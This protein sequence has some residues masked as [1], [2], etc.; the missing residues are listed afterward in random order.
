MS[1]LVISLAASTAFAQYKLE[2]AAALPSGVPD[3]FAALLKKDGGHKILAADGKVLCEVWMRTTTPTGPAT[4]EQNVSLPT[5]PHGSFVG[6]IHFPN[7]WEDRRG[8]TIKP[9]VYTMRYSMF[10]T[11]GDHQGAAPQRDFFLLTPM[12]ND[13]DPAATPGFDAL[14]DMSRKASN[15]PHPAVFSVWKA[16]G[17]VE[18][19]KDGEHD[20]VLHT[21]LGDTG[22][23]II[24]VGRA[25]G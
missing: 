22:I 19:G 21:K 23:A 1:L 3:G 15:T 18:L 17:K 11:N 16:D 5:V 12:A 14:M 13:S 24:L 20:W 9:G 8:Q 25:E 2:S 6:V 4:A 10:P 7:R